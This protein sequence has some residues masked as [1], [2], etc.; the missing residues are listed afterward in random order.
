MLLTCTRITSARESA[1]EKILLTP[2]AYSLIPLILT[3]GS[4]KENSSLKKE[5]S[6]LPVTNHSL[7]ISAFSSKTASSSREEKVRFGLLQSMLSIIGIFFSLEINFPIT[8]V[9]GFTYSSS[10][11]SIFALSTGGLGI[12]EGLQYCKR[13]GANDDEKA[14]QDPTS[15]EA[16][17]KRW[18]IAGPDPESLANSRIVKRRSHCCMVWSTRKQV[19][20]NRL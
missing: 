15:K 3:S 6:T 19:D 8:F 5:G 13:I 10:D 14:E 16:R 17:N 7:S 9:I 2:A 12:F 4:W 20:D 1:W 11:P 18:T